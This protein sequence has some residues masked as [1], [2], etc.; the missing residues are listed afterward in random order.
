MFQGTQGMLRLVISLVAAAIVA[1]VLCHLKERVERQ[2][3]PDLLPMAQ[4]DGRD[5]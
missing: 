2:G 5:D 1:V 3:G 4:A